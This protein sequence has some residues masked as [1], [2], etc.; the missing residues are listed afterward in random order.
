MN[1][2]GSDRN[3][4]IIHIKT[5]DEIINNPRVTDPNLQVNLNTYVVVKMKMTLKITNNCDTPKY[6]CAISYNIFIE[7]EYGLAQY[8]RKDRKVNSWRYL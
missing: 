3:K 5:E 6:R 8:I 1:R 7:N 4:I 2:G